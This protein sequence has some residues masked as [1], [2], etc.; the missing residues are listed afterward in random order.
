[1][2]PV[3]IGLMIQLAVL[4]TQREQE[5]EEHHYDHCEHHHQSPADQELSPSV[6]V[7]RGRGGGRCAARGFISRG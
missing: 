3:D 2:I 7:G 4:D 5:T 1:M 6:Y